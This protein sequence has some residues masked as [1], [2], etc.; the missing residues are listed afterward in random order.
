MNVTPQE[1]IHDLITRPGLGM[2]AW[3]CTVYFLVALVFFI[4]AMRSGQ[5]KDLETSKFDMLE[6]SPKKEVHNNG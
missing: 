4:W 2:F 6:D 3:L 5:M 1:V